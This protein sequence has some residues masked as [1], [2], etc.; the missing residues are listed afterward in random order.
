MIELHLFE[1]I[2]ICRLQEGQRDLAEYLAAIDYMQTQSLINKYGAKFSGKKESASG[3]KKRFVLFVNIY[4]QQRTGPKQTPP[5]TPMGR[6][7]GASVAGR[8]LR[9]ERRCF[10]CLLSLVVARGGA[11]RQRPVGRGGP[12]S[13]QTPTTPNQQ[14]PQQQRMPNR[15]ALQQQRQPFQSSP[16]TPQQANNSANTSFS[17]TSSSTPVAASYAIGGLFLFCLTMFNSS[18]SASSSSLL[19]RAVSWLIGD[20]IDQVICVVV[21]V[22]NN[23]FLTV[24]NAGCCCVDLSTM[25]CSSRLGSAR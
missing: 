17:S 13:P 22:V 9:S 10:S 23:R 14:Q 3:T 12:N 6:G 5:N 20:G 24:S 16:A 4:Q 8:S 7:R 11:L 1:K 19:D 2:E 21:C 25:S 18:A 15:D